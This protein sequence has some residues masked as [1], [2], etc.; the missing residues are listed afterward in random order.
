[1][2]QGSGARH[3]RQ[4]S[5]DAMCDAQPM[6][7]WAKRCPVARLGWRA[8]SGGLDCLILID[9]I[10]LRRR[11]GMIFQRSNPFPMSIYDNVSYGVRTDNWRRRETSSSFLAPGEILWAARFP[12]HTS[13][14]PIPGLLHRGRRRDRVQELDL[15]PATTF[16]ST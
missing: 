6:A 3:Q 4:R 2:V 13:P 11:I 10:H 12:N 16:P 14:E 15:M 7:S 8:A 5:V 9:V 1:M